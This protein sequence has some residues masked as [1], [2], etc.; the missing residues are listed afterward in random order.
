MRVALLVLNILLVP[1]LVAEIEKSITIGMSDIS[2]TVQMS[3][4]VEDSTRLRVLSFNI[5]DH[6]G[7]YPSCLYHMIEDIKAMDPGFIG[8]QEVC[9]TIGSGGA[10]NT[11]KV[12]VDSLT[13]QTGIQYHYF[14]EKTH[15]AWDQYYEGIAIITKYPILE[16]GYR[17]L[18]SS[19]FQR[20]VIWTKVATPIGEINFYNTHL[21]YRAEDSHVREAQVREI[22]NYSIEKDTLEAFEAS[23]LVGDFNSDPNTHAI[24]LLTT[25][26]M[27]IR[28]I[29]C[30]REANPNEPGYTISSYNPI[31]RI[32]YIFLKND[33][34][35]K[36]DTS[37]VIFKTPYEPNRYISDHL[38]VLAVFEKDTTETQSIE[39]LDDG[40]P[41][42]FRLY[43]NYP[44]PFNLSTS[45]SYVIPVKSNVVLEVY[46]LLGQRVRTLINEVQK[47]DNYNV[48]WD[49]KDN[50]RV[51]LSD[52][53]YFYRIKSGCF[54]KTNKMIL[55]R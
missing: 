40:Y 23:I 13:N 38:G 2:A 16:S 24:Q 27:S 54:V 20:K 15:V 45:I 55:L 21:A 9:E 43:Q 47:P 39:D 41:K 31:Q 35:V 5:W 3:R 18:P 4:L 12:I 52:G 51:D 17:N 44:N 36:V 42:D 50:Q 14:W 33:S 49:G 22:I 30:F 53:V 7:D 37:F 19:V 11:A 46:N 48:T 6:Q 25:D 1:E 34:K 32:D 10:D 8:L 28:Y 29:D 26:S